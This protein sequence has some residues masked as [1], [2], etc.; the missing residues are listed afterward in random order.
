[1]LQAGLCPLLRREGYLPVVI[2]LDYAEEAAG[3]SRQVHA[4]L[5][6]AVAAAHATDG[7]PATD[8]TLW[9]RLHAPSRRVTGPTGAVLIPALI[10]DQFEEV[11]TF[12]L[13]RVQ[14][15]RQRAGLQQYVKLNE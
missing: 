7:E 15:P 8:E 1:M 6:A 10:F 4:A 2:R 5:D 12:G 14:V 13:G 9:E 3:L 11:F